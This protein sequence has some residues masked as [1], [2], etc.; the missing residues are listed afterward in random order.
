[1]RTARR[2][3]RNASPDLTLAAAQQDTLTSIRQVSPTELLNLLPALV[4]LLR[5]TVNGGVPF[6]R[7]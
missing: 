1:M 6:C 2:E 7:R 5:D 4:E 3:L